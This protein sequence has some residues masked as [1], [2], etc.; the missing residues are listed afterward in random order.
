MTDVQITVRVSDIRNSA[1]RT[2]WNVQERMA[3]FHS[4]LDVDVKASID[5]LLR[6]W[7]LEGEV[8]V[9]VS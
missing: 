7:G 8:S 1:S 2:L 6:H 3:N 5:E 4:D 9:A